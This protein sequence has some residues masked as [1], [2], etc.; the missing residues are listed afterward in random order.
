MLIALVLGIIFFQDITFPV[1]LEE[2]F[3]AAYYNQFGPL[4][5]CVELLVAGL[6]LYQGHPKA[7]FTLAL[8]GFSALLDP[9][10]NYFGIFATQ[11][12]VYATVIFILCGLLAL[13]L[14]FT[15]TF[16]TGRISIPGAFGSF[17]LGC[18]VELFF[19]A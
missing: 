12:P 9:V 3:K 18:A 4:A 8:F 17:I 7:N 10:F 6:Y 19:N 2:Y 11:L 16:D 15:N 1:G 13:W 5:L 14:A